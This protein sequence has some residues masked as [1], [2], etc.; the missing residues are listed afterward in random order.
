MQR[1]LLAISAS[2]LA[3]AVVPSFALGAQDNTA[4]ANA[5][6]GN[7]ATSVQLGGG[8]DQTATNTQLLPI[9]AAPAVAAQVV[10]VNLN[11]P[12]S[13]ASTGGG[14]SVDQSNTAAADAS[15]ANEATSVQKSEGSG[16]Q[17]AT[18]TQI[19]P[20]AA[21]PAVAA[22]VIPVN[23]NV[24]VSVLSDAPSGDVSQTNGAYAGAGAA[25]T[26]ASRQ[27]GPKDAKKGEGGSQT[28]SNTQILP[29][30]AAP[31]ISGQIL[32]L[33]ANVP[34]DLFTTGGGDDGKAD[35]TSQSNVA[36]AGASAANTAASRQYGGGTQT[37]TNTQFIPISLAPAIAPQILPI[38]ANVPINIGNPLAVLP[39]LPVDPFAVLGDPVGAVTGLLPL[40]AVTGLL[41]LGAVTGLLPVGLPDLGAVTGLL[42][43]GAVT[44]L[45]PALPALPVALPAL[46][47]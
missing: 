11:L 38:N 40:G 24:P 20:I 32:P 35:G 37:A 22:Q 9:A 44:G 28:A 33:N 8:G 3:L 18:N 29:I 12:I 25:N 7:S 17:T 23:A 46:P 41:P 16:S 13:V 5:A 34:V 43:L 19:V 4:A 47:I 36:Y 2:A 27:E 1:H 39:P 6:A 26:A 42:P 31:A 14:G 45:L 30:A 10:P 15:A 21:A